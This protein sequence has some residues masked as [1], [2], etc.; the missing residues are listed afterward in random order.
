MTDLFQELATLSSDPAYQ[1]AI[2]HAQNPAIPKK[3]RR[4]LIIAALR[5]IAPP[6][7]SGMM[8]MRDCFWA[9]LFSFVATAATGS[10]ALQEKK[11]AWLR[12]KRESATVWPPRGLF[13]AA[14]YAPQPMRYK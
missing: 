2:A 1:A 6:V 3:E 5:A 8:R 9:V 4:G 14:N 7:P 13:Q 12:W 10:E 11:A